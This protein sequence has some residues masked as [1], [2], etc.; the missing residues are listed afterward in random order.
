MKKGTKLSLGV[1]TILLG[2]VA[3]SGCT[4]SF[5]SVEDR[6]HILYAYDY[7]VTEYHSTQVEG[8]VELVG[9]N[10]V[11]VTYSYESNPT[12]KTIYETAAKENVRVP[13]LTYWACFDQ[14]V[15]ENA[16]EAAGITDTTLITADDIVRNTP[17]NY[18]LYG[19]LSTY[20]YLKF[21]DSDVPSGE[22]IKL[23]D[24]WDRI[25]SEIRSSG[26]EVDNLPDND[27]VALYKKS[28]ETT[29]AAYRSCLATSDGRY[30]Y[31]GKGGG[32]FTGPV[33]IEGKSWSY[34]WSKG[35]FEGLLIYPIGWFIDTITGGF[36]NAGVASGV[37]QILAIFIVTIVI[38]SLMLAVT[39]KS[40]TMNAKMTEIQPELAKIQAKYPN[41]NTSQSE[42]MRMGEEMQKLYKKHG[43]NPFSSLL[44]MIVQFPVFICVWGALSGSALLSTGS[45]LGLNLS[46]SIS[47]VLFNKAAWTASG[48]FA[49]VT[50][51]VLF[52][53]MSAGQV[54]S[55][56]LP[57]WMQKAKQ[58][59]I[60]KMGRNPAKKSQDS[61][62]KIF[63]YVMMAMVIFMGFSLASGMG[64][65]WFIG[66]LFSIA[67]TLITHA[68]TSKKKSKK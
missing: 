46:D 67:Q 52:L 53:L 25:N 49:A 12:L 1:L 54:I 31:Y 42:K 17:D 21:Y 30:G 28:L 66:A 39:F 5:C 29:T 48:G 61:K 41:S 10:N 14:I 6:A 45:F 2:A 18:G 65:Y 13:T 22:K 44:V 15:L 3:L 36:L 34:A 9:F 19:I 16:L 38:R 50:A 55:M 62:M 40:T 58:K 4:A 60:A 27:F 33:D 59:K 35:L 57:Q 51:L 43:I 32:T 63:T 26:M 7:G 68:I 56:L 8:S 20:G 47:T 37:A 64:V 23:W 11:Y 24:N